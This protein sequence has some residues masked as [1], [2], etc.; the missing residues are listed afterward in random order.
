MRSRKQKKERKV[1]YKIYFSHHI[2]TTVQHHHPH[3]C[4]D[5][6]VWGGLEEE[7]NISAG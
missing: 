6:M 4:M 7:K 3:S 1:L 5:L 2:A